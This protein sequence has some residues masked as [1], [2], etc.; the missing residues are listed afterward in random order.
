MRVSFFI[1][2][3]LEVNKIE[4]IINSYLDS[5]NGKKVT[6]VLSLDFTR[7]DNIVKTICVNRN[8]LFTQ[9]LEFK[10]CSLRD[11]N[12]AAS[13]KT[14]LYRYCSNELISVSDYIIT[15]YPKNLKGNVATVNEAKERNKRVLRYWI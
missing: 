15:I 13:E 5:E 1:H 12:M 14:L 8:I 2:N 4:K 11:K 6:E 7:G 9:V 3:E 10:V